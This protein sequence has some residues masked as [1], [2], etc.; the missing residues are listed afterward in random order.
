MSLL[1]D[2]FYV[3][4]L[5][6]SNQVVCHK[7]MALLRLERE[8]A[9]RFQ[10]M[11]KAAA[12][13]ARAIEDKAH[14]ES[15]LERLE[16]EKEELIVQ[17]NQLQEI[18]DARLRAQC[19]AG[20]QYSA[21]D[22]PPE[23][24]AL[25]IL[26]TRSATSIQ[27]LF[28]GWRTR[29]KLK[30]HGMLSRKV[31]LKRLAILRAGIVGRAGES[32]AVNASSSASV[33]AS[34]LSSLH[35]PRSFLHLMHPSDMLQNRHHFVRLF[36]RKNL[37]KWILNL[38]AEKSVQDYLLERTQRG[39][40]AKSS[41]ISAPRKDLAE[42]L[43]DFS[44]SKHGSRDAA[45]MDLLDLFASV[46]RFADASPRVKM[47]QTTLQQAWR[48]KRKPQHQ[49]QRQASASPADSAAAASGKAISASTHSCHMTESERLSHDTLCQLRLSLHGGRSL[50]SRV[51]D[52]LLSFLRLSKDH[53]RGPFQNLGDN[54][55]GVMWIEF[56]SLCDLV[57]VVCRRWNEGAR[58]SLMQ[59]LSAKA[60]ALGGAATRTHVLGLSGAPGAH[61]AAA[62]VDSLASMLSPRSAGVS[63]PLPPTSP[64][65]SSEVERR[66]VDWDAMVELVLEAY[67]DE[68]HRMHCMLVDSFCN[69]AALEKRIKRAARGGMP[70]LS[71][72][73]TDGTADIGAAVSVGGSGGESLALEP[74]F[75]SFPHFCG[76]LRSLGCSWNEDLLL[77]VFQLSVQRAIHRAVSLD[78]FAT[79]VRAFGVMPVDCDWDLDRSTDSRALGPDGLPVLLS[80]K[81]AMAMATARR[82]DLLPT[83]DGFDD[84]DAGSLSSGGGGGV[85][86]RD[87][88]LLDRR[89]QELRDRL[90]E[91][92]ATAQ[93]KLD[94]A[95]R[96]HGKELEA[97]KSAH[98]AEM[99]QMAQAHSAQMEAA[100]RAL[101]GEKTRAAMEFN[102]LVSRTASEAR[103][104]SVAAEAASR[105]KEA[106][107]ETTL[108]NY[109]NR[110]TEDARMMELLQE[111]LRSKSEKYARKKAALATMQARCAQAEAALAAANAA[112][113]AATT[114]PAA[115]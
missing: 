41:P 93:T 42:F 73:W 92:E 63:S 66:F 76:T 94:H 87:S 35:I 64:G 34:S 31:I 46:D 14:L 115:Q 67:V 7:E 110:V 6:Y 25:E 95:T 79:V 39:S 47:F 68:D 24:T 71:I 106:A 72:D 50:S 10:E 1:F 81:E 105:R 60:E 86:G 16:A 74:E 36:L 77:R 44:I 22:V 58:E 54:N 57:A 99:D 27:G 61:S 26:Q 28:R 98:A 112:T 17:C 88:D 108:A 20:S 4:D 103:A 111:K 9:Q 23:P 55:D 78:D 100:R 109:Q 97:L 30:A 104:A 84:P 65:S 85:S 40:G 56:G 83:I 96:K 18:L 12:D 75:Y 89:I 21:D 101:D 5:L 33:G 38:Y 45:E 13:L 51:L 62:A 11:E 82:G 59:G 107:A 114:A 91:Q 113:A 69:P 52:F 2:C 29:R 102:A 37:C 48:H 15:A 80:A 3:Q 43:Y 32:S 53:G 19:H 49:H 70:T 90:R 8:H